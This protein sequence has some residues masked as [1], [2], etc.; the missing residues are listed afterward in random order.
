M[1]TDGAT[2]MTDCH[3]GA[4]AKIK[5]VTHKEMLFTHCN[6]HREPLASMKLSPDLKNAFDKAVKI[7]N[8]IRSRP[9]NS[10]LF[11]ALCGSMDSHHGH[12]LHAQVRWLS[13]GGVFSRLF[14][15]RKEA[16][17]FL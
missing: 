16:K 6:I 12:L 1:C 11:Q 7:V 3:C 8:A 14:Q 15:L 13:P 10:R 4:V 2:N 17:H 9:F 5:E